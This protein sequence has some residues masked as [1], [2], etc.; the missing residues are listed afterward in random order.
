M[1]KVV[2][3]N[4]SAKPEVIPNSKWLKLGAEY[5]VKHVYNQFLQNGVL[6]FVL[7]EID[8]KG[9]DPYNCFLAS[10]FAVYP[11]C[12]KELIEMIAACGELNNID[13]SELIENLETVDKE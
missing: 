4:N 10:R 13:V 11:E 6:A 8:L 3:I 5:T 7:W 9:C 2:C 12:L 1:I